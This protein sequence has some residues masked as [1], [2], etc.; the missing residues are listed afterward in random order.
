MTAAMKKQATIVERNAMVA[1]FVDASRA[2]KLARSSSEIRLLEAKHTQELEVFPHFG[3]KDCDLSLM[4]HYAE[5]RAY[6]YVDVSCVPDLGDDY[7]TVLRKACSTHKTG[8]RRGVLI[9]RF[10][11]SG[12]TWEQV[13]GLFRKS[14]IGLILEESLDMFSG[15]AN[16]YVAEETTAK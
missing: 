15:D 2:R 10:S 9:R 7:T 1:Q 5:G 12:V 6:T 14:G 8:H 11:A 13:K 4:I 3:R 16:L